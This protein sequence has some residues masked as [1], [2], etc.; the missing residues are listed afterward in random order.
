MEQDGES[1]VKG[2]IS[3]S[4]RRTGTYRDRSSP[5]SVGKDTTDRRLL[6]Q[7]RWLSFARGSSLKGRGGGYRQKSSEGPRRGTSSVH[8][9]IPF[10]NI[11][12]LKVNTL[13]VY[14]FVGES[15]S[16]P[17]A[18]VFWMT[19]SLHLIT[20]RRSTGEVSV[21]TP[22]EPPRLTLRHRDDVGRSSLNHRRSKVTSSRLLGDGALGW[23]RGAETEKVVV[24][25]GRDESVDFQRSPQDPRDPTRR[26]PTSVLIPRQD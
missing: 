26:L 15:S 18:E 6:V 4:D 3:T 24:G 23:C 22:S 25:D 21:G 12:D 1:I 11:F 13:N 5:L 8:M 17:S 9:T 19:F 20:P 16:R 10:F 14:F 2:Q 7:W